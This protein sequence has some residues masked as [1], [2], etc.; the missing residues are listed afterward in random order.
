MISN[1]SYNHFGFFPTFN[2]S[3][4]NTFKPENNEN[5]FSQQGNNKRKHDN[6]I[7]TQSKRYFTQEIYSNNKNSPTNKIEFPQQNRIL[8]EKKR[9]FTNEEIENNNMH[10]SKRYQRFDPRESPAIQKR[11]ELV[12]PQNRFEIVDEEDDEFLR[13][14]ELIPINLT[15]DQ[16]K[17]NSYNQIVRRSNYF[18]ENT[19]KKE[20]L[21]DLINPCFKIYPN[22]PHPYQP[23]P[24]NLS[25]VLYKQSQS[26]NPNTSDRFEDVTDD[27]NDEL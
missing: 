24:D 11:E 26:N 12:K 3:Q 23:T 20:T 17:N 14:A 7:S 4:E 15:N 2:S 6:D 18:Q 8:R 16:S 13:S 25:I 27:M 1:Q 21:S 9:S 19:I 5:V 22:L 10:T